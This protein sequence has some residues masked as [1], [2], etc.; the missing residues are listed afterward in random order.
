[1]SN[2]T[3]TFIILQI[4]CVE[5]DE[6]LLMQKYLVYNKKNLKKSWEI[7]KLPTKV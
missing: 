4:L 7:G 2:D 1:M 5:D 3:L 6:D